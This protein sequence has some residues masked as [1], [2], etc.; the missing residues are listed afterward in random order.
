MHIGLVTATGCDEIVH[1]EESRQLTIV[2]GTPVIQVANP[3]DVAKPQKVI[4][5]PHGQRAIEVFSDRWRLV[6]AGSGLTIAERHGKTPRFSPGGRFVTAFGE[7]AVEL[8]DAVDGAVVAEM[9][10]FDTSHI[11][12]IGWL[13]GDSFAVLGSSGSGGIAVYSTLAE[14][15]LVA[16]GLPGCQAC[17][18]RFHTGLSLDLDNNVAMVG[19]M[20]A[21][22]GADGFGPAA[23]SLTSPLGYDS[24]GMIAGSENYQNAEDFA[25][26]TSAVVPLQPIVPYVE[27]PGIRFTFLAADDQPDEDGAKQLQH[28]TKAA[29]IAPAIGK[30][31][32]ER[33]GLGGGCRDAARRRGADAGAAGPRRPHEAA[34][35]GIRDTAVCHGSGACGRQFAQACRQT[36]R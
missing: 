21:L 9:D 2:P 33:T 32:T 34:H 29:Y 16:S 17:T 35:R 31:A 6:D 1:N 13:D 24:L 12:E 30:P 3:F 22:D 19:D 10:T 23:Q 4:D 18:A 27:E 7:G 36:P 8:V 20:G 15:R 28:A 25:Y 14:Q 26:K 11:S 5:A